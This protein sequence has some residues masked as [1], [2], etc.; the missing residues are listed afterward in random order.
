MVETKKSFCRFGHVFCG[1]E[2]EVDVEQQRVLAV[3]GDRDLRCRRRWFRRRGPVVIDSGRGRISAT[4]QGSAGVMSG[5]VAMAH[6]W[7]GELG[8]PTGRLIPDDARF[9]PLTGM[10]LLNNLI[11]FS[12]RCWS[13]MVPVFP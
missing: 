11:T 7:G 3:R 2:V 10:A 12:S 6:A 4:V 13:T 1:I 9:D 8:S 5:V